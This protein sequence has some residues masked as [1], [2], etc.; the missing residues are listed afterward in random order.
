L[1]SRASVDLTAETFAQALA[2]VRRFRPGREPAV[3]WL[4]GI[5]RHTLLN[6]LRRGRVADRARS[7]LGV[8][9]ITVDDD[10]LDRI[11][12]L[13]TLSVDELLSALPSDQAQAIKARVF[14]EQP[15]GDVAVRL[16]CSP[17]VARKR[18][19]R[20]LATLRSIILEEDAS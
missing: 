9:A 3:A 6:S 19:S 10:D 13:G 12:R 14:D 17:L 7:R 16:R 8:P 20:G 5:A 4:F 18:V 2:S 1:A 11:D 15:Y